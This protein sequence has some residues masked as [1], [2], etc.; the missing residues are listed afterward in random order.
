MPMRVICSQSV[1]TPQD[2]FQIICDIQNV[3]NCVSYDRLA[4]NVY[5]KDSAIEPK[6]RKSRGNI[7]VQ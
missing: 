3:I 2:L 6:I 5:P 4:R 7:G 1:E